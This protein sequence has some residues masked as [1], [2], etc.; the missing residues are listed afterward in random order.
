MKTY[1]KYMATN[2][3][4]H[5]KSLKEIANLPEVIRELAR[6]KRLSNKKKAYLSK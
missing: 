4:K 2:P 3:N 6:R 5:G 1:V